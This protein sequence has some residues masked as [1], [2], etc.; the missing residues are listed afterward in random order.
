MSGQAVVWAGSGTAWPSVGW[1][2]PVADLLVRMGWQVDVVPWGDPAAEHQGRLDVLHVFSGGLEPVGSGT[3]AMADRLDAVRA[4]IGAAEGGRACVL[5]I[6]LGAQMIA[7]VSGGVLP[8]PVPGGGEVGTATL[9]GLDLPDLHVPDLHVATAHVQ[10]VPEAYLRTPGVQLTWTGN[11]TRV[12]GF[13]L[14]ARVAGVQFHPELDAAE[15]ARAGQ[16]FTDLVGVPSADLAE[17]E[18]DPARSLGAVLATAGAHRLAASL[19][20]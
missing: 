16:A 8:E 1:G 2:E 18:L 13:T 14:G 3:A 10:Q 6:C 5:G 9:H 7:A 15:A 11:V 4:G 17:G 12:Q 19:A 20:A